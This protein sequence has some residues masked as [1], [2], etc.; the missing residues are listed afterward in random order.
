MAL[1]ARRGLIVALAAVAIL[2]VVYSSWVGGQL[3]ALVVLSATIQT[4]VLTWT[5][6]QLTD[7]PRVSELRVAG[8]PTTLVRPRDGDT[9]PALVFV[10]GATERGR[11][12]PDV[13]RLA[14]GLARAGYLVVV[15][16]LPGLRRGEIT[17]RT[18]AATIA[19]GRA[20]AAREDARR[21]RVGF[22]GVSVGASLGLLAAED[23]SLLGRVSVVSGIAPYTDLRLVTRLA[24]TGRYGTEPYR[25]DP[26][27][28]LAIARS[29]AAALP[30]G[31]ARDKLVTRLG[32]VADDAPR[33]LAFL[34]R[35]RARGETGALI[36]LL[37][38]EDPARFDALYAHLPAR[39]RHGIARLSPLTHAGALRAPIE[40]ATAPHDKYFPPGESRAL[41]RTAEGADVNVT[42][43]R[44]LSHAIPHP[45]LRD[46]AGLIRFDGWV[47]RSLRAARR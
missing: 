33:P 31:P 26:F 4:P 38:N 9:W 8:Q 44:A 47:V 34:R 20:T 32:R 22:V 30:P 46:L 45:S 7:D 29:L 14:R 37:R 24:L 5:A 11:F 43:T 42:V 28:R 16:D 18:A 17:E 15:P 23:P 40:L 1:T 41:A 6:K 13:Q 35:L 3:R 10:N 12:H 2:I 19:V 27:V 21:G 36:A 25:V 39:M